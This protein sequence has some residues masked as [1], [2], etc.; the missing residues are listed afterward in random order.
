MKINDVQTKANITAMIPKAQL[1]QSTRVNVVLNQTAYEKTLDTFRGDLEDTL[2]RIK[3]EG[4]DEKL[5]KFY[6]T[7]KPESELT[8]EERKKCEELKADPEY[9]DFKETLDKVNSDY[10]EAQKKVT[11]DNDYDVKERPY[12]ESDLE[13][14]AT[15]LPSGGTTTVKLNG[16]DTAVPNDELLHLILRYL[17]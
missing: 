1:P 5:Q 6:V 10:A 8:D 3:P 16:K 15:A 4:F 9:A 13:A 11:E 7:T 14:I 2:K 12:T 17:V